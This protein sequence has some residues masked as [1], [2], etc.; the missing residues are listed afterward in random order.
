MCLRPVEKC[1]AHP[2]ILLLHQY[3]ASTGRTHSIPG[4]MK[5]HIK[6]EDRQRLRLLFL[7]HFTHIKGEKCNALLSLHFLSISAVFPYNTV[8]CVPGCNKTLCYTEAQKTR[9]TADEYPH[10]FL[11]R[12]SPA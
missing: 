6:S 10:P 12:A 2:E 7:L 5:D 9:N 3:I 1:L 8:Y 11:L 4:K